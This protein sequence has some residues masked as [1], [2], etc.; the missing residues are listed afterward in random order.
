MWWP[1]A[2]YGLEKPGVFKKNGFNWNGNGVYESYGQ[3]R[4]IAQ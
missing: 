4:R 3:Y 2:V 1:K